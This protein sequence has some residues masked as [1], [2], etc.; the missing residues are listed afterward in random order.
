[1][2]QSPV[3]LP[4]HFSFPASGNPYIGRR[5]DA[6][7]LA[8]AVGEETAVGEEPA[9][10]ANVVFVMHDEAQECHAFCPEL[11]KAGNDD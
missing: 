5:V 10:E 11:S 8:V 2:P 4:Y 7:D 6:V 1:M 3:F 9:E